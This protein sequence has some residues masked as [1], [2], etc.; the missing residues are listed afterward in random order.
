MTDAPG[1]PVMG[2]GMTTGSGRG[3]A[4]SVAA[5]WLSL[6]AAPT[7]AAM[8]LWTGFGVAPEMACMTGASPLNAMALMYALMSAVH[9]APWLRLF[10]GRRH[11][12]GSPA[13]TARGQ[14]R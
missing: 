6:T 11:G 7:F 14:R 2:Y 5:G 8:A 9:A 10:S 12:G 3:D 4:A 1:A 13:L